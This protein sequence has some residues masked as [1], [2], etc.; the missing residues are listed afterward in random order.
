MSPILPTQDGYLFQD[1]AKFAASFAADVDVEKAA[2]IADSQVPWR[3]PALSGTV[4]ESAWRTKPSW[5]WIAIDDQTRGKPRPSG[6]G[7]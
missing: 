7:G 4:I 1:K 2:F 3:M 6:R 5:Y